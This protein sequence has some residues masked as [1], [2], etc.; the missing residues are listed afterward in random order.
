MPDRK[1]IRLQVGTNVI[2]TGAAYDWICVSVVGDDYMDADISLENLAA[3][4]GAYIK[5]TRYNPRYVDITIRSKL[6][7]S[8]QIDATE[9]LLKQYLSIKCD[10]IL[11]IYK[12]GVERV[13]YG[14]VADVKKSRDAKWNSIPQVTITFLMPDP[15]FI[16]GEFTNPFYSAQPLISFP[17]SFIT[18]VG[19]TVSTVVSG[20]AI[21]LT[22]GGHEP[23]GFVL[24]L[25]ASGTVVN[26]K[27]TVASGDYVTVKETMSTG[28][29][30]VISTV[31][32]DKYTTLNG[33][34]C[35]YDRLSSFPVFEVGSNI[36]DVSADSGVSFLTKSLAWSERYRG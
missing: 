7:S 30:V 14:R 12:N 35:R 19:L 4:D 27:V 1:E 15:W 17:L 26:P 13:G 6:N 11:T 9:L 23:T 28:D 29:V 34:V 31:A 25:T 10:S 36:V 5:N 2:Q 18:G 33:V 21:A 22:V 24:T 20:N 16:G 8:A 32:R 3:G